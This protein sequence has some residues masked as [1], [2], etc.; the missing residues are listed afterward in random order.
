MSFE[1]KIELLDLN[2]FWKKIGG[3]GRENGKGNRIL[4]NKVEVPDSQ[5]TNWVRDY[6]VK[7][8]ELIYNLL[9]L[10]LDTELKKK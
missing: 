6:F 2:I 10:W 1:G 5:P 9:V 8:D 3:R 7:E 4:V